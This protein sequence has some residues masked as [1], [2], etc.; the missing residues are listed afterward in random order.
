[1]RLKTTIM[2][3]TY[4]QLENGGYRISIDFKPEGDFSNQ[5]EQI[6]EITNTV[7]KMAYTLALQGLDL[8]GDPIVWQNGKYTSKGLKKKTIRHLMEKFR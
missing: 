8:N 6:Q 7:G 1:L 3:A 2:E 5:E 4:T